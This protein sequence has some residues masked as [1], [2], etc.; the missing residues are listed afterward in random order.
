MM[1]RKNIWFVVFACLSLPTFTIGQNWNATCLATSVGV[2]KEKWREERKKS[3]G[4][5]KTGNNVS[6]LA[7][8]LHELR[9]KSAYFNKENT[10][11]YKFSPQSSET[12]L[13][14]LH[15]VRE[16]LFHYPRRFPACSI[17]EEDLTGV[18]HTFPVPALNRLGCLC[19][20]EWMLARENA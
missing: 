9:N 10:F 14:T 7:S 17:S 4:L 11:I 6:V 16:H 15:R 5:L 2:I 20:Y 13:V 12:H 3:A 19:I 18:A 8:A 1:D